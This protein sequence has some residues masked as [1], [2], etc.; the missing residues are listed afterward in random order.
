MINVIYTNSKG[1]KKSMKC[2]GFDVRDNDSTCCVLTFLGPQ[3]GTERKKKGKKIV[4]IPTHTIL[5]RAYGVTFYEVE[6]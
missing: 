1:K 2:E 5:A 3:I 6:E 4:N